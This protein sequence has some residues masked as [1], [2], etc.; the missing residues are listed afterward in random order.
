VGADYHFPHLRIP[1]AVILLLGLALGST[2]D[3]AYTAATCDAGAAPARQALLALA[4]GI[5][6]GP[7]DR[8]GGRYAY[9]HLRQWALV[10]TGA[11]VPPPIRPNTP[12]VV[13]IEMRRWTAEDG[14][15]RLDET[16]L[17]PDYHLAGARPDYRSTDREFA[18]APVIRSSFPPGNSICPISGPLAADPPALQRQLA[19]VAGRL[20]DGP[21]ATLRAIDDLYARC[22]LAL[23]TRIAVLRTLA[24][25]DAVSYRTNAVDRLG[26]RAVAVSLTVHGV[27]YSLNFDRATG[28]LLAAQQRSIGA[29][30]Y[31]SVPAGLVCYYTLFVEQARRPQLT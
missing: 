17:A 1:A 19:V 14:S 29:H 30:P 24:G 15:G 11:P 10:T 21:Q 31:L 7:Q 6:P 22:Y 16:Q 12:V 2:A 26:R 23:P 13:A 3:A 20:P 8:V 9:H 28:S 4:R 27:E 25:L 5:K 18:G